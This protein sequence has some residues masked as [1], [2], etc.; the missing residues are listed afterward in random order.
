M[1]TTTEIAIPEIV[2]QEL[3][4]EQIIVAQLQDA[5]QH[6]L[7]LKLLNP[8]DKDGYITIEDNRK[9]MMRTRTA[10]SRIFKAHRDEVN[11]IVKANLT[12]EKQ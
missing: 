11:L 3:T 8:Q 1:E 4:K 10:I 2:K 12:A 9:K 6:C 5:A 7:T